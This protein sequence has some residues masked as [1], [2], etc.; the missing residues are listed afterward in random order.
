MANQAQMRVQTELQ[1]WPGVETLNSVQNLLDQN[2]IL[3]AEINQVGVVCVC[4]C[5]CGCA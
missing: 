1:Q 3:I 4:G 5:G 2:K